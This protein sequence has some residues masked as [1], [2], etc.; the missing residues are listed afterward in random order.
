MANPELCPNCSSPLSSGTCL[1]CA[2][3]SSRIVHRD[4]LLLVLLSA[5]AV[6]LF[7]FTRAM[8]AKVREMDARVAAAWFGEGER[9]VRTGDMGSAIDS[10]RNA[11]SRDHDNRT[12][13]LALANAL[14]T[15]GHGEEARQSLLRLRESSPENAEINLHL[16]RLAAKREDVAEALRYHYGS[17]N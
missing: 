1:R 5:I 17:D 3:K 7:L 10:F 14:A 16:A 9:Q 4:I 15:A 2:E 8:A 13:V 11:T 12:Y 6:A